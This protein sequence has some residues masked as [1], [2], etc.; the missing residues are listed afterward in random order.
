MK[1]LISFFAKQNNEES[2]KHF[3][4]FALSQALMNSVRGG[5]REG[6]EEQENEG[7]LRESPPVTFWLPFD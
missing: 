6:D 2:I 4:N 1:T 7:I 5:I 3:E